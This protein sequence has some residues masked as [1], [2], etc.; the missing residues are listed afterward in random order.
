MTTI[1]YDHE[2]QQIA[3]DSRLVDGTKILSDSYRKDILLINDVR[4]FF[5]GNPIDLNAL[6]DF[7][8]EKG[9]QPQ[10]IKSL[11]GVG[12]FRAFIDTPHAIY[13]LFCSDGS[14]IMEELSYSEG[15]GSGGQWALAA[16]DLGKSAAEAVAY[17]ST[18]DVETGGAIRV[19]STQS[20]V[21][22]TDE[23]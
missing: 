18:R 16:L 12:T 1:V 13:D 10:K 15:T 3:F 17:A 19:W 8:E 21:F 23:H 2:N 20:K 6:V 9:Y 22:I 7:I 11:K 4:W 14:Y 5:S